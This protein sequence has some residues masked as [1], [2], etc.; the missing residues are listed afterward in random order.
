MSH[1]VP[2]PFI[3][4][5]A[6]LPR[7]GLGLALKD[8]LAGDLLAH[9]ETT[10]L[11]DQVAWLEI[12]P[13]NYMGRGG[14]VLDNLLTLQDAGFPIT[15]HGVAMSLG[16][17]D[18]LEARYLN[19]LAALFNQVPPVWF[20]DHLSYARVGDRHLNDLF[21]LPFVPQAV[22]QCV[23]AITQVQARFAEPFL[24]ENISYYTRF[25]PEAMD[26]AT[27][28]TQVVE[29]ADCGLLLDVNNVVVNT[30]NHG[31]DPWAFCQALPLNRV[32]EIH[33]A[34]HLVTPNLV[35]DTHGATA[36]EAV[37]HLLSRIVPHCPNLK[38]ILLE[39]DVNL[40]PF[41]ELLQ[42]LH[43]LRDALLQSPTPCPPVEAVA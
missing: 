26:E 4:R 37:V 7:L 27:F 31:G 18:G 38:G 25:T 39:R 21:P 30:L 3:E 16:S 28:L 36:S 19:D 14:Q 29:G 9:L 17:A 24:I 2:S 20:S 34:G 40:P 43:H 22:D 5:L 33:V 15:S 6:T 11:A 32:V 1:A 13:E 41:N 8:A 10:D 42:E 23:Q 12:I 35:I